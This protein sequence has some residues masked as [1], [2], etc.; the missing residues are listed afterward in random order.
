[1]NTVKSNRE[2][3]TFPPADSA[4]PAGPEADRL[5]SGPVSA[6]PQT[7]W[8]DLLT[9]AELID[10][11]RIR[12]VCGEADPANVIENLKRTRPLPCLYISRKPLYPL[13]DIREWV[14]EQ[15]KVHS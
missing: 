8:P 11:L 3:V 15:T 7:T 4:I 14:S 1:V 6:S 10:F 2:C 5:R 9:E 13:A 12:E